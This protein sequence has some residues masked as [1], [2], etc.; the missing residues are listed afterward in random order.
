M[1]TPRALSD[2]ASTKGARKGILLVFGQEWRGIVAKG[3]LGSGHFA[4]AGNTRLKE[5][6]HVVGHRGNSSPCRQP[7]RRD[8]V[9]A[10][11][12]NNTNGIDSLLRLN[13]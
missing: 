3:S 4:I 9:A 7:N 6:F 2:R 10:A 8:D 13:V 5:I 11:Q 12:L 1:V